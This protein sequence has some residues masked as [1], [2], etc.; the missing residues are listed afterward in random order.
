M[1]FTEHG[2]KEVIEAVETAVIAGGSSREVVEHLLRMES[3]AGHD[4]SPT[5]LGIWPTLPSPN[6]SVYSQIGGVR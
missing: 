6:V 4:Y 3:G 5:P 2:H 1:L